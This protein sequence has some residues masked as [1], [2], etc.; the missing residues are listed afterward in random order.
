AMQ[1]TAAKAAR[2]IA[3]IALYPL[4]SVKSDCGVHPPPREGEKA[5]AKKE[6]YLS[7]GGKTS[8]GF[9]EKGGGRDIRA[10]P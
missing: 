9:K 7:R 10:G 2:M 4:C 3:L 5:H 8:P 1:M 6:G